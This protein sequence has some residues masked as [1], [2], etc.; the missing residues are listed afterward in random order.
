M[1]T[2][3]DIREEKNQVILGDCLETMKDIPDK[4]IDMVLTDPPYELDNHGGGTTDFAQRKLV[5]DLHIDFIS[6]SFDMGAVFA[7]I[8]RVSKTMNLVMFCSNKQVSKIMGYW[9]SRGYSTTLLVWDKP[10]P[11]PFGNGKYISSIEFIVY[12]RGK[13]APYNSIG[14]EEQ[15]KTF[16]YGVPS[17][18]NR[19]HPTEKP[20]DMLERLIKIH[21]NEGG[22]VLDPFA[23][24]GSTGVACKNLKRN[25]IL[26]EKEPEYIEIIKKRLQEIQ[27]KLRCMT[28]N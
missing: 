20:V 16:R 18:K 13:N 17:S 15:L 12:V 19:L 25:Y 14:Y 11:V 27:P 10:N 3:K 2:P 4:S 26:I 28:I 22:I 5:K 9:E 8:E 1:T 23:G 24:S 21:S 6:S 7:E